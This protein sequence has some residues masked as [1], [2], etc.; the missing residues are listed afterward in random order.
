MMNR[1]CAR[2]IVVACPCVYWH[3]S[4][5]CFCFGWP[6]QLA[7]CCCS[8]LARVILHFFPLLLS[9]DWLAA[10]DNKSR[11]RAVQATGTGASTV[12]VLFDAQS[13]SWCTQLTCRFVCEPPRQAKRSLA[14]KH[15]F[16]ASERANQSGKLISERMN[17]GSRITRPGSENGFIFRSLAPADA[18]A[19]NNNTFASLGTNDPRRS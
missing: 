8:C 14:D 16:S 10:S 4:S 7:R 17:F 5:I 6:T 12:S 13:N 19:L 2:F 3:T 1:G 15:F 18:D 11:L 9:D